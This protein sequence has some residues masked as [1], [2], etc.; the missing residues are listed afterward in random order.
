[1]CQVIPVVLRGEGKKLGQLLVR[2]NLSP[3]TAAG[4]AAHIAAQT[5]GALALL[6]DLTV[7]TAGPSH[8]GCGVG[9]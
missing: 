2:V 3:G 8:F 4:L 1:M 5:L 7:H 9:A 6:V